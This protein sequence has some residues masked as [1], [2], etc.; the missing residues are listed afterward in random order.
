MKIPQCDRCLL[1]AH[2]PYLV[3]A[4]HPGGV[5]IETCPD[6]RPD[7]NAAAEEELWAPEGYSWYGDYLIPHRPYFGS[8]IVLASIGQHFLY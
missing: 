3:C 6:F 8:T 2:S 4:V 5:D 1:S 7:P